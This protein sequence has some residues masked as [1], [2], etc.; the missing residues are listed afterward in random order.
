[1]TDRIP[2]YRL[3]PDDAPARFPPEQRLPSVV[4][5]LFSRSQFIIVV[6]TISIAKSGGFF[7]AM[8]KSVKRGWLYKLTT[9]WCDEIMRAT[10]PGER[11][12]FCNKKRNRSTKSQPRTSAGYQHDRITPR[13]PAKLTE[14]HL[15]NRASSSVLNQETMS[16]YI[17][18]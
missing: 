11:D 6:I 17:L 4:F 16:E 1:M 2:L 7:V 5:L 13:S 12:G 9:I 14:P 15:E 10:N 3:L 18:K 8:N